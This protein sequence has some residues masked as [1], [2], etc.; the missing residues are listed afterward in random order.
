MGQAAVRELLISNGADPKQKND[1]VETRLFATMT[2]TGTSQTLAGLL[3]LDYYL[4]KVQ[5]GRA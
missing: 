1:D 5:A 3:K 4:P 2:D